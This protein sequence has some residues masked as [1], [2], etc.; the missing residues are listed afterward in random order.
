MEE[1]PPILRNL[2]RTTSH[3][4]NSLNSL[5]LD[6]FH[7]RFCLPI[8]WIQRCGKSFSTQSQRMNRKEKLISL[9]WVSMS[10]NLFESIGC[11]K[12]NCLYIV[13]GIMETLGQPPLK[14]RD[15]DV[16]NYS[17]A[18]VG[19]ANRRNLNGG[20]RCCELYST[21][22][23]GIVNIYLT[24]EERYKD[25]LFSLLPTDGQQDVVW[26]G[27]FWI[28]DHVR[29]DRRLQRG[30]EHNERA[31]KGSFTLLVSYSGM[32]SS[33]TSPTRFL[34]KSKRHCR[35]G[36]WIRFC[37]SF[38]IPQ[39]ARSPKPKY[40]RPCFHVGCWKRISAFRW[41]WCARIQMWLWSSSIRLTRRPS[42]KRSPRWK[43]TSFS[44]HFALTVCF[45][46]PSSLFDV[47]GSSLIY[48]NTATRTN[49]S[50]A[51]NHV[52]SILFPGTFVS[53]PPNVWHHT[54]SEHSFRPKMKCSSLR[55]AT[56]PISQQ[57]C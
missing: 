37:R 56:I 32:T 48:L 11:S 28:S 40:F 5:Q 57:I 54:P 39:T 43:W 41:W 36:G 2:G 34:R 33:P 8:R 31:H 17:Y 4:W 16:I 46:S 30:S 1:S 25:I 14:K 3:F 49:L 38:R 51:T 27:C 12:A 55:A 24:T 20:T 7:C 44:M 19:Y 52:L 50:I 22:S 15:I 21:E 29:R 53:P 10:W 6:R 47:D 42:Q 9:S 35:S 26:S 18:N 45:V 13:D 23:V